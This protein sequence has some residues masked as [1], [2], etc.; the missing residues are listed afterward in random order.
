MKINYHK[1][2]YK[3]FDKLPVKIREKFYERLK[4]FSQNQ[5]NPALNNHALVGKYKGFR[6]IDITGD[7]RAI[8]EPV[9]KD[10]SLFIMVDTHS[11]LYK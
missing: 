11:N 1:K 6:S 4:I 8:F 9:D 2:F 5:F 7:L 10:I 3:N